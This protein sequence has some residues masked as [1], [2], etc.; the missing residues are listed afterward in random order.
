MS[1]VAPTKDVTEIAN[2]SVYGT[3]SRMLL[4]IDLTVQMNAKF[5]PLKNESKSEL[6][7]APGGAKEGV[8]R[9]TTNVS[10]VRLMI[11]FRVHLIIHQELHL[12]VHCKIY[13][14]MH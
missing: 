9:T 13:I 4:K 3:H 12:G 1:Q 11:Q 2:E 7:S 5:G 8:N 14:K 10:D 6:F